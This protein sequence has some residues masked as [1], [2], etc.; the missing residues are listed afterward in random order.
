VFSSGQQRLNYTKAKI[1]NKSRKKKCRRNYNNSSSKDIEAVAA[2]IKDQRL[3]LTSKNN[4]SITMKVSNTIITLLNITSVFTALL[5]ASLLVGGATAAANDDTCPCPNEKKIRI[6]G[7]S[8]GLKSDSFW[9]PIYAGADRAAKDAGT[10]VEL[11]FKRFDLGASVGVEG[12]SD[13]VDLMIGRIEEL[14]SSTTD[15]NAVDAIFSSLNDE[16]VLQSLMT[17]CVAKN[18]P[19]IV[20][21]AGLGMLTS[22]EDN[23]GII[24]FVGTDDYQLGKSTGKVFLR[25]DK[26]TKLF[27][28][29]NC[30]NCTSWD[31]RCLGF[32]DAVGEQ[33]YGGQIIANTST[34]ETYIDSI[35]AVVGANGTWDGTGLFLGAQASLI[36]FALALAERH[37]GVKMGGVDT[38]PGLFGALGQSF[39]WGTDQQPYLQG[40]MPVQ[41]LVSNERIGQG[42]MTF[43]L[44]TG[45]KFLDKAPDE[46]AA[47]CEDNPYQE[48]DVA[49][50]ESSA[51]SPLFPI[52]RVVAAACVVALL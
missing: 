28:I 52:V 37:P 49:A 44:E 42:L 48:C 26:L 11:D 40:M 15:N 13:V 25:D 41:L 47:L 39:L 22:L 32:G 8:H 24:H 34:M 27:C 35:E 23:G 38:S 46:D 29:D 45:P 9:D 6:G 3:L 21:N 43:D 20:I 14:C 17:N 18:I 10:G 12:G 30:S 33:L 7:V 50:D 31:Q 1:R 19:T 36:D 51:S 16:A 5:A 2:T 4:K